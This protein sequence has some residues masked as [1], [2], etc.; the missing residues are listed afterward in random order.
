MYMD[1][2]KMESLGIDKCTVYLDGDELDQCTEA[3]EEKGYAIT[4]HID[5]MLPGIDEIPRRTPHGSVII[6]IETDEEGL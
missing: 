5:E 1:V 6:V 2:K 3:D 4:A